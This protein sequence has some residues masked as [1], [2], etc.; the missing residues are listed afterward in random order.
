[1]CAWFLVGRFRFGANAFSTLK[2]GGKGARGSASWPNQV[3]KLFAILM[4]P[5]VRGLLQKLTFHQKR[6]VRLCWPFGVEMLSASVALRGWQWLSP[7]VE[8][9]SKAERCD[10]W[11]TVEERRSLVLASVRQKVG[12]FA[13]ASVFA[14]SPGLGL[15]ELPT[16]P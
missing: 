3:F 14:N 9:F 12:A 15:P 11:R 13:R 6:T 7:S 8:K 10:L 2:S 5:A 16:Q 1:M 4:R